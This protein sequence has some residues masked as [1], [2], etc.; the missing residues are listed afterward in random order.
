MGACSVKVACTQP[1]HVH[2]RRCARRV[3]ATQPLRAGDAFFFWCL[4]L[5]ESKHT[6]FFLQPLYCFFSIFGL[7]RPVDPRPRIC[8]AAGQ[9][10]VVFP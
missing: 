7:L 6:L 2:A 1:R 3:A 4:V 8:A 9:T 5:G 10:L